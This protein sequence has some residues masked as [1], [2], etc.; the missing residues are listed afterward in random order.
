M[1]SPFS[2]TVFAAPAVPMKRRL[3]FMKTS[4]GNPRTCEQR[5]TKCCAQTPLPQSFDIMRA[6]AT[7]AALRAVAAGEPLIEL[8]F[9]AVPNMATAALN[10]LLDANRAYAKQFMLA[11]RARLEGAVTAL[12]VV[13]QD[14][15][16]AKLACDAYGEVPFAIS[17]LPKP[18]G[19]PPLFVSEARN[20]SGIIAVIQPG[21]NVD[22]WISMEH[23]QGSLPVVAINADL[24][25]VRG[26]YYPRLFYP[27]LHAVK[28][29]FLSKFVEAYYI[30]SFSNGGILFRSFP[31]KWRL[32]YTL[33]QGDV[34]E[35]W[36]GDVRPGFREVERMLA[37]SREED[38]LS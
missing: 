26:S 8:F 1:V 27:R 34:I 24:D 19:P 22:E 3:Y 36:S 21:F 37:Q 20:N 29:R 2:T 9:P 33:R 6:Q 16:E 4:L 18:S 7:D 38:L 14:S 28:D 25:K 17:V 23:L 5:I 35:I 13:F 12:H 31:G 32:F 15:A 11:S 30:K 10:Q